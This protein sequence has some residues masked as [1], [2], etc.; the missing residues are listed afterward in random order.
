V[1]LDVLHMCFAKRKELTVQHGE[2]STTLNGQ[3][4]HYRMADNSL[5]LMTLNGNTVELAYDPLDMGEG[6]IYYEGRFFGLVKC[7]ELRRMGEQGFVQDEKDRRG[8]RREIRRAIEVAHKLAPVATPE[9]RLARRAEVTPQRLIAA[10][11][12][13]P[14][15]VPASVVEATAAASEEKAFQFEVAPAAVER[16]EQAPAADG[17]DEFNFFQG[18]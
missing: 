13:V 2:V 15:E 14:V 1:P 7:V 10:R 9:E 12:E 8:A 16:L 17:E 3:P 11:V 4:Y 5:R 18:D 6:A